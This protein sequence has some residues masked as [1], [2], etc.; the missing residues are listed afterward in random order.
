MA[1]DY[2]VHSKLS[3]LESVPEVGNGSVLSVDI[4]PGTLG[5]FGNNFFGPLFER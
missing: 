3:S 2:R 5:G 4:Q 1:K